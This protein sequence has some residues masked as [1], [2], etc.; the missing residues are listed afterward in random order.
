MNR[1]MVRIITITIVALLL[2]S[3]IAPML[4]PY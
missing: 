3:M 1:K 2:F 4:M